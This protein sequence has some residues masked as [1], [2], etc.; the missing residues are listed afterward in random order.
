M[1]VRQAQCR[2]CRLKADR[3]RDAADWIG[4]YR[5]HCEESLERLDD[6][7]GELQMTEKNDGAGTG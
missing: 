6:Y 2:P 1:G 4:Q 5:R 3:L 7:L